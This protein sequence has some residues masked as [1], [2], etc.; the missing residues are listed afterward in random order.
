[1]LTGRGE[2]YLVELVSLMIFMLGNTSYASSPYSNSSGLS[3]V[4]GLIVLRLVFR[5]VMLEESKDSTVMFLLLMGLCLLVEVLV[6]FLEFLL[7]MFVL[8]LEFFS[9]AWLLL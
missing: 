4:M 2:S 8:F 6:F 9:R 3:T 5:F 1:M 7:V